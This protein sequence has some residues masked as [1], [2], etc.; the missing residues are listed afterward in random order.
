MSWLSAGLARGG[1]GGGRLLGEGGESIQLI[2][3]HGLEPA[4][5]QPE[6]LLVGSIEPARSVL[7]NEHKTG[8]PQYT[9]VLADRAERDVEGIGDLTG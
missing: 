1:D 7:A 5:H 2:G 9:E 4:G 3:P 8:P 6:R